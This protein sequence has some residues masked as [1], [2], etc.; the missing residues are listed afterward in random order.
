VNEK[1]RQTVAAITILGAIGVCFVLGQAMRGSVHSANASKRARLFAN[2]G[3]SLADPE[4]ADFADANT[5]P[6]EIFDEAWERIQHDFVLDSMEAEYLTELML[7]RLIAGTRDSASRAYTAKQNRTRRAALLDCYDGIGANFALLHTKQGDVARPVLTIQS[8]VA[9]SP[10]ASA[11]LKTGDRIREINGRWIIGTL[12]P[13][14]ARNVPNDDETGAAKPDE[15]SKFPKGVT[16]AAA[17]DLLSMGKDKIYKLSVERTGEP[18]PLEIEVRTAQTQSPAASFQWQ[19]EG[20]GLLTIRRF[21]LFTHDLVEK[22]LTEHTS[23]LHGLIVDLRQ[24]SGGVQSGTFYPEGNGVLA[25]TH[26][27]GKL[28][29]GGTAAIWERHKRQR[30]PLQIES[31]GKPNYSLAVL[32]DKGTANLAEVAASG[33]RDLGRAKLLGTPTFGDA[34]LRHYTELKSGGALEI[35]T[36]HLLTANGKP[37]DKGIAPDISVAPENALELAIKLLA[38][39]FKERKSAE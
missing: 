27:L 20:I 24:C 2:A 9:G 7:A 19:E 39:E 23:K 8:V 31:K 21:N 28:T 3:S 36:A 1:L 34:I 33:L 16:L 6:S 29:P 14:I 37:M 22:A 11:G 12:E 10:A 4:R 5:D 30:E 18:A 38:K 13:D 17:R 25:L 32:I 35:A 26:L 15:Q